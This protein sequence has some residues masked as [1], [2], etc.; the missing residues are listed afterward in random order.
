MTSRFVAGALVLI[1]GLLV[2]ILVRQESRIERLEARAAPAAAGA[3]AAASGP[4]LVKAP[5]SAS[6][7]RSG[8]HISPS[9]AQDMARRLSDKAALELDDAGVD[10]LGHLLAIVFARRARE[11]LREKGSG[12]ELDPESAALADEDLGAALDAVGLT[13]A[14]RRLVVGALPELGGLAP[15]SPP[16]QRSP[17]GR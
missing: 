13:P 12:A 17:P 7:P 8:V 4:K 10:R 5:L 14:Q 3:P 15:P 9:A 1:A 16:A 11:Q 2:V 6:P